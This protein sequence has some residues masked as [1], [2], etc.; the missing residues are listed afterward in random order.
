MHYRAAMT[1]DPVAA[2]QDLLN[3]LPET[4]LA[5]HVEAFESVHRALSDA[6]SAIDNL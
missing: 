1:D 4:P 2:A 6:L 3:A 5:E